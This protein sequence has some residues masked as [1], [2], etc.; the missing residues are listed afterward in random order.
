[1]DHI[2]L[3]HHAP[4]R[5]HGERPGAAYA[6][7]N[8]TLRLAVGLLLVKQGVSQCG[9][10]NGP[11]V[12]F[13]EVLFSFRVDVI[14][15]VSTLMLEVKLIYFSFMSLG[16]PSA[17]LLFLL[18]KPKLRMEAKAAAVRAAITQP[19]SNGQTEGQVNKLKMVKRQMY[20]RAKVDLLEAR[21]IGAA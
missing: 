17:V 7:C 6:P 5:G 18:R 9:T 11:I 10:Y 13:A 21:L 14:S 3:A 2:V 12:G 4:E 1:L 15:H 16:F 8:D 19:W 20:G